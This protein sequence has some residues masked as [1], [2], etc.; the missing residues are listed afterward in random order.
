M[1]LGFAQRH[2]EI[3]A[4]E[5]VVRDQLAVFKILSMRF[6]VVQ[7]SCPMSAEIKL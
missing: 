6:I 5:L 4:E 7:H 3:R 2:V 1:P